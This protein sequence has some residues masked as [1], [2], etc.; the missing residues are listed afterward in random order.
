MKLNCDMKPICETAPKS[1]LWAPTC[2]LG[3]NEDVL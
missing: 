2:V 3:L 1:L